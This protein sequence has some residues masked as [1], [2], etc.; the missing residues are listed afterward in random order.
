MFPV[1]PLPQRG[2]K[3]MRVTVLH[4][5][6]FFGEVMSAKGEGFCT[7]AYHLYSKRKCCK[8]TGLTE[9]GNELSGTV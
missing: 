7:A 6:I 3:F 2:T 5:S 9:D 4:F 1:N 8:L